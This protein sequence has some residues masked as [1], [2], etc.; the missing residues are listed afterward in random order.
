MLADGSFLTLPRST[1]RC[2]GLRIGDQVD[3]QKRSDDPSPAK[4]PAA[5]GRGS[6]GQCRIEL[7]PVVPKKKNKKTSASG[8][9]RGPSAHSAASGHFR[10]RATVTTEGRHCASGIPSRASPKLAPGT[11]VEPKTRADR[12]LGI[13][14]PASVTGLIHSHESRRRFPGLGGAFQPSAAKKT[15]RGM[16]RETL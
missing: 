4:P 8:T 2:H 12:G 9:S 16:V 5:A 7:V 6:L 15:Y 14:G 1:Q 10:W 13:F 3:L 11:L